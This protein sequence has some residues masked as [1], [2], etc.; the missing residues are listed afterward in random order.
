MQSSQSNIMKA[1]RESIALFPDTV[2]RS[3]SLAHPKEMLT[4]KG[5]VVRLNAW[6][7]DH[8]KWVYGD[9]IGQ[10]VSMG[11]RCPIGRSPTLEGEYVVLAGLLGV[12]PSKINEG[13]EV[14]LDGECVGTWMPE[15]RPTQPL[16][17]LERSSGRMSLSAFIRQ[18]GSSKL[19]IFAS[20]TGRKDYVTATSTHGVAT[21]WVDVTGNF[22]APDKLLADLDQALSQNKAQ[23]V[24]FVRGGGDAT[25][26]GFWDDAAFVR[27]LLDRK[28][29]FYTAIGHSD[30]LLL[31]DKYSDESFATPTAFGESLSGMVVS[32]ENERHLNATLYRMRT[33]SEQTNATL[34]DSHRQADALQQQLIR[35]RLRNRKLATLAIMLALLLAGMLWRSLH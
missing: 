12:H 6:P 26:L 33:E 8:P 18:H 16:L 9:L 20:K 15:E 10:E 21:N 31:A 35:S 3:I 22:S 13:L 25:T 5:R 11:F 27:A 30:R 1:P 34:R 23:G 32:L 14:R 7:S 4:V 28:L 29:P 24:A 2:M 19:L 17:A